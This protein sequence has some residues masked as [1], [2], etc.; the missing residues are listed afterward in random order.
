MAPSRSPDPL[1][2]P[3][4]LH[5]LEALVDIA[6]DVLAA[7]LAGRPYE[8]PPVDAVPEALRVRRGAFV[9]LDVDGVLNGCIGDV[10]GS[11]PLDEAIARLALAA[12]FDDPRLPPLQA[13]QYERLTIEVSVLSAFVP[14]VADDRTALVARLRPHVDG[15][16]IRAGYR[17]GLFLPGVWRQ[18][19]E[20]DAFLDQ[21]WHK[22]GLPAS[23]WPDTIDRFTTQ[24]LSRG[25]RR[26]GGPRT[27]RREPPSV[28]RSPR[29]PPGSRRLPAPARPAGSRTVR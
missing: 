14:V 5:E 16:V 27:D 29:R 28:S 20:P 8:L 13:H 23:V 25:A 21:L 11:Q 24:H 2:D 7:A 6:E 18:L 12:A 4:E 17:S 26:H 3:L 9:T 22:A 15:V 19:P 10:A 1:P